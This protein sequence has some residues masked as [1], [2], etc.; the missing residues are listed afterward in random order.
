MNIENPHDIKRSRV[1]LEE[2]KF[3]YGWV[4]TDM[5]QR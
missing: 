4:D 3:L 1:E 5:L 2:D